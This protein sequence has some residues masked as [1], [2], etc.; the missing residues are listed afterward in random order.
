MN[1]LTIPHDLSNVSE[2]VCFII[3]D[4]KNIQ[5]NHWKLQKLNMTVQR[6]QK[7]TEMEINVYGYPSRSDLRTK[8]VSLFE[9][10]SAQ[11]VT[12]LKDLGAQT[13]LFL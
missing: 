7:Q 12:I 1:L 10:S 5:E 13:R 8:T 2:N 4:H 6:R 9:S 11:L 3:A